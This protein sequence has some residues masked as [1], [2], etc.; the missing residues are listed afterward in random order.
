MKRVPSAPI[1][2]ELA[3]KIKH[4]LGKGLYQHQIASLLG[5]NQGRVS[6]VNTGKIHP[7]APLSDQASFNFD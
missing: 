1:T 4:L 2:P 5:I 3:T 6:E 7:K